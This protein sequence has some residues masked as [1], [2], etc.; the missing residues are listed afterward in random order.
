[1]TKGN[2]LRLSQGGGVL[3]SSAILGNSLRRFYAGNYL[4]DCEIAAWVD[5]SMVNLSSNRACRT[6]AQME[7]GHEVEPVWGLAFDAIEA[8]WLAA[9]RLRVLAEKRTR[10]TIGRLRNPRKVQS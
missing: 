8:N 5:A 6:T 7:K 3:G 1:M 9:A 4:R 2:F 10:H